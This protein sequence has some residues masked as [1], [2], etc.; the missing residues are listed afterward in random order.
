MFHSTI[1]YGLSM[2]CSAV[3]VFSM[4]SLTS[5]N[6][7]TGDT[8]V[9]RL[10][11]G[12]DNIVQT[13]FD[14]IPGDITKSGVRFYCQVSHFAYDDSIVHKNQPGKAHLHM[15]VGNTEADAFT[16][17]NSLKSKGKSSC[18]SGNTN[19]SAYWMP[20]VLDGQGRPVVA[21][22][23]KLY[24]K[25]HEDVSKVQPIPDNLQHIGSN[26]VKGCLDPNNGNFNCANAQNVGGKLWTSVHFANCL[27][28]RNGQP[29]VTSNDNSH[30]QFGYYQC[31]DSHP[32]RIPMISLNMD[33]PINY[34]S[35]WKLSSDIMDPNN[36]QPKGSTLHADIVTAWT[37]KG[38]NDVQNCARRGQ[39]CE[40]WY[41]D[42]D[43][44]RN[45]DG[46]KVFDGIKYRGPSTPFGV[47]PAMLGDHSGHSSQDQNNSQMAMPEEEKVVIDTQEKAEQEVERKI[48]EGELEVPETVQ[49][50]LP[51]WKVRKAQELRREIRKI[52]QQIKNLER[53]NT[54][55]KKQVSDLE[56]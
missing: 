23:V 32:Y 31:P 19:K 45:V 9:F 21:E 43:F 40:F 27:Q 4:M 1:K 53:K 42:D 28:V 12:I 10:S 16:T 36:P 25:T 41:M 13:S 48:N 7:A 46:Q 35:D 3:M 6:A 54:N 33:F 8:P 29:V 14:D 38:R 22:F 44:Q 18:T 20:A 47:Q 5:V 55:L 30:G 52:E 34:N 51:K 26:K 15:F 37:D 56:S 11:R 17:V 49:K 50:S 39:N 24:Y 2:L